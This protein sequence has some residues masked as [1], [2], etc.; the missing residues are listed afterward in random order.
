MEERIGRATIGAVINLSALGR[1]S[2]TNADGR[3]THLSLDTRLRGSIPAELGQ[4]TNLK[5]LYLY[6]ND[7]SGSIPAELGNL[8]NLDIPDYGRQRVKWFDSG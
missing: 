2:T 1:A 3:V 8:T 7:L 5:S 6:K 4:L